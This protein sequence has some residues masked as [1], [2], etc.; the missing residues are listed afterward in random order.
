[1]DKSWSWMEIVRIYGVEERPTIESE[2]I[3]KERTGPNVSELTFL[4]PLEFYSSV[5]LFIL[6]NRNLNFLIWLSDC[7]GC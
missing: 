6:S 7:I 4:D 3:R 5:V 2:T 1:M